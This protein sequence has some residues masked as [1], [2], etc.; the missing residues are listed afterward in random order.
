[1]RYFGCCVSVR[2]WCLVGDDMLRRSVSR[3]AIGEQQHVRLTRAQRLQLGNIKT[4]YGDL[5]TAAGS[6]EKWG[7]L[8]KGW[9]YPFIGQFCLFFFMGMC[10]SV[11]NVMHTYR[12]SEIYAEHTTF[13]DVQERM[14]YHMPGSSRLKNVTIYRA[15]GVR[16]EMDP[17]P[18]DWLPFEM[19]L[20]QV[21]QASA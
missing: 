18:L 7:F 4:D 1:M 12:D 17:T 15:D 14:A 8:Y 20:G 3:L 6:H 5:Q 9:R 11:S 2:W 16:W 19:K 21:K 13:E 10:F